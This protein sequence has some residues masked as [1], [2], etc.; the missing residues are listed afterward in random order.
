M[1]KHSWRK[2]LLKRS[3]FGECSEFT[4]LGVTKTCHQVK[5]F[6]TLLHKLIRTTY[7][8]IQQPCS[9]SVPSPP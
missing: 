1:I 6:V 9:Y 8:P 4:V 2:R 7:R 5:A 3:I